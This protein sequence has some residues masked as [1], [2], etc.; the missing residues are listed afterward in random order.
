MRVPKGVIVHTRL[1]LT[2]LYI[3]ENSGRQLILVGFVW[4]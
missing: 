2:M 1:H 4:R 3:V